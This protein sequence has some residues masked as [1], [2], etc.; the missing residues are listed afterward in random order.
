M[1]GAS[2][3]LF[4]RHVPWGEHGAPV[5]GGVLL[6]RKPR[7]PQSQGNLGSGPGA[8]GQDGV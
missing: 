8:E 6:F 7:T 3:H 5:Q 4:L 2:P 1:E